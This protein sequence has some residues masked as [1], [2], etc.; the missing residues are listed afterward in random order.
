MD[1]SEVAQ[2][3]ALAC[4][5]ILIGVVAVVFP[6]R[7]RAR[8][9]AEDLSGSSGL[10]VPTTS[11]WEAPLLRPAPPIQSDLERGVL[12]Q[13]LEDVRVRVTRAFARLEQPIEPHVSQRQATT[14]VAETA[15]DR[16]T[17][18]LRSP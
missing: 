11:V 3:V 18:E 6:F 7:R 1:V 8:G 4:A 12:P 16:G 10:W 17:T 9:Q 2:L 14:A 13:D 15:H 5:L